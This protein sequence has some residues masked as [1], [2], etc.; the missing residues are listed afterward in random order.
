MNELAAF[1]FLR[2]AWL[3]ALLPA[4]AA[5][6]GVL[7]HQDPAR[8]LKSV[9]APEM[10]E[11]LVVKEAVR[12]QRLRPAYLLG[13]AWVLATVALAGPAWQK[14]RTPFSEDRSALFIVL[15]AT[16]TM[17]ARDVQPSRIT[18]AMQKTGDLLAMRP[19]THTGLV[20]YAGSAH[21]VMPL[22]T[23]AEI[24]TYFGEELGPDV[25]PVPGDDPVRAVQLAASRLSDS[26]MPGSIVLVA[27]SI[28]PVAQEGLARVQRDSGIDTHVY[29]IAAGPDVVPP[30]GSPPAPFLDENA[31]RQAA[32]AGG[33]A[34]V[35]VTPDDS[36]IRQMNAHVA[37]SI[38]AAPAQ[39]GERWEDAGYWLLWP[40]LF[41]FLLFWR[42]GGGVQLGRRP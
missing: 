5:L 10:L 1:H 40:L 11:H 31:M 19:G 7:R 29:A 2:P 18:R 32:R 17:L 30:A 15:K 24:I 39:E 22:T 42:Q 36:D 25:I 4:A 12:Q 6:W 3:L 37:R 13:V 35:S 14:E 21:L 27:D 16:P 26:G 41:V 34:Y 38:A 33:G 20:A 8:A 23:D 9:I 28:D